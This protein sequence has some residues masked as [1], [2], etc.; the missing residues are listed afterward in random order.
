MK[1]VTIVV[2]V[3]LGLAS[4]SAGTA[5]A[6]I[7][8]GKKNF[9]K[10]TACHSLEAGKNG[11]GPTLHKVFGRKAAAE[12]GFKYSKGMKAAAA[13]GLVWDRKNL[14]GYLKHPRKFLKKFL[15]VKKVK[16]KMANRF[17]KKKFR[18]A[19]VDYLESLNKM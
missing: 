4:L 1:F 16:N 17:K 6:D 13:K 18:K 12:K 11:L 14:M 2:A 19:V 3:L 5:S 15:G 10:C 7:A 8:K 9:S